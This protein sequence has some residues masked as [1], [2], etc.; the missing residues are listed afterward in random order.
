MMM[1]LRMI[2]HFKFLSINIV[3]QDPIEFN[4][5]Q[6]QLQMVLHILTL[7]VIIVDHHQ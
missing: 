7:K 4:L 6:I 5:T 1:V 2:E 3:E